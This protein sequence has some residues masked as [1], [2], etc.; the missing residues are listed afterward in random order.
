MTDS[1]ID[2]Q[3]DFGAIDFFTSPAFGARPAALLRIPAQPGAGR[4]GVAPRRRRCDRVRRE[5]LEVFKDAGLW[6]NCVAVGGPFPPLPFTPEGDDISD[7]IDAHRTQMPLHEHMV[8]MDP[9]NHTRARS[10]LTRLLTPSR[11]K[12][13]QDFLWELADSQLN[14]F[15]DNGR[16]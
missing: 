16:V 3:T 13:N 11:L 8:A 14:E 12:A 9:P 15:V 1:D 10:I 7:L 2:G 4:E 6:S 5:A